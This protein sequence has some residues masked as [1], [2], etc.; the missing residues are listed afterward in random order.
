MAF[1]TRRSSSCGARWR[2]GAEAATSRHPKDIGESVEA[3]ASRLVRK[4]KKLEKPMR[5]A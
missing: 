2:A 1:L 5:E 4:T 3:H